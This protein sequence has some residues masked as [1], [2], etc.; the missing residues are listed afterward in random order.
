MFQ[1]QHVFEFCQM[2]LN[3]AQVLI[4]LVLIKKKRCVVDEVYKLFLYSLEIMFLLSRTNI[5]KGVSVT[6][7]SLDI[8]YMRRAGLV[9][10]Y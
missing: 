2:S 6:S 8:A 3:K 10:F 1:S 5:K 4:K 7:N 9:C